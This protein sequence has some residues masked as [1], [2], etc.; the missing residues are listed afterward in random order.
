MVHAFL[1]TLTMGSSSNSRTVTQTVLS[2]EQDEGLGA[3]VRRSVGRSEVG[4]TCMEDTHST[5][6]GPVEI[7]SFKFRHATLLEYVH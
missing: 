4:I 2:V 3:R 7:S 6:K 1:T 5:M